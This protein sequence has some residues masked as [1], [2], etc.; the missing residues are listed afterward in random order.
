MEMKENKLLTYKTYGP[1]FGSMQR[2]E[3]D[4]IVVSV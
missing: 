2:K 1:Q 3:L 4:V